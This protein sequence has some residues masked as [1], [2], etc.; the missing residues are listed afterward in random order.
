MVQ[1]VKAFTAASV[2]TWI[3]I[4]PMSKPD[5][6]RESLVLECLWRDG[7]VETGE[8][9]EDPGPANHLSWKAFLYYGIDNNFGCKWSTFFLFSG[10]LCAQYPSLL[11]GRVK[12]AACLRT[13]RSWRTL[14]INILAS[15]TGRVI[16]TPRVYFQEAQTAVWA[17]FSSQVHAKGEKNGWTRSYGE[18][19]WEAIFWVGHSHC[20]QQPTTARVACNG[21]VWDRSLKS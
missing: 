2:M 9:P 14:E 6:W 3:Q 8:A 10:V 12:W 21:P 7:R 1:R 18:G 13:G 19:P 16:L 5:I 17:Q 20:T 15:G 11:A 4:E